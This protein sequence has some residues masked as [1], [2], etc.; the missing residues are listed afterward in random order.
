MGDS[1]CYDAK[2]LDPAGI[3]TWGDLQTHHYAWFISGLF[4]LIATIMSLRLMYRHFQNYTKPYYQRQIIR[5][6]MMVPIYSVI[7]WLSFRYYIYEIYLDVFRDCYEAF[8][9]YSFF[10]L[11][12]NYLGEDGPAQKAVLK[13]KPVMKFCFPL[14]F[15]K[16]DPKSPNFL[17]NCRHGALQYVVIR[18]LTTILSVITL[19]LDLFCPEALDPRYAHP[20]ILGINFVSVTIAMYALI[21]LYLTVKKDLAPFKPIPKFVS[22]KFVIFFSFWQG[23]V[24][25]ILAHYGLIQETDYWTVDNVASGI[26]NFLICAEM[27]IAAGMHIRAFSYDE[28]KSPDGSRTKFFSSLLDSINPIDIY[29]DCL[30]GVKHMHGVMKERKVIRK[31]NKKAKKLLNINANNSTAPEDQEESEADETSDP[32][33]DDTPKAFQA[34][35]ENG[36]DQNNSSGSRQVKDP[37]EEKV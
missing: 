13:D 6:I 10:T 9:I 33:F 21:T 31:T 11:L 7:S 22:V 16:Y 32:V 18:P 23:L 15:L 28:Y 14:H 27:V 29:Q 36:S 20:Y 30:F 34:N 5:I 24:V 17:P 2:P 19:E 26:Q 25:S 37:G 3:T 35:T 8:V 4:A 1:T 12:L